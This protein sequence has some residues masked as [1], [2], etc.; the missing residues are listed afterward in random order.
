M[1]S[2]LPTPV[3]DDLVAQLRRQVSGPV[4]A[5][6]DPGYAEECRTYNL[7]TPLLPEVAVGA[8]SA[9]DVQAAVRLAA[10]HGLAVAI[11]GGGHIVATSGEGSLVINM[12]RMNAVTVDAEARRVRLQGSVLWQDVLDATA[13]YGLAPM[14]GSS[15]TVSAVG[16][17]LGGG[18]SPTLG[19]LLGWAA[20]YVTAF[21]LVTA[22]GVLRHVTPDSDPDLFFAVRGTKGNFG[23]VTALEL[24][25]FPF[26]RI[27]AGG[28]WFPGERMA[29]VLTSWREWVAG[30]PDEL[31]SSIAVQR[32]PPLPELPEPL[33]GAFVVHVRIAYLGDPEEGERLIRPLRS[34]APVI[35]D[36]VA[37]LPYAE[38]ATLHLD[39]PEPLPY[40]DR[41]TGLRDLTKETVDA[42][43][44]VAGPDSGCVLASI[45]IRR[46]GGALAREPRTPDA[47]PTRGLEFQMFAFGV[48]PV[49]T[50]PQLR[51][52]L[53]GLIEAV[54]PWHD[55]RRLVSF[56]SPDEAQQQ[57]DIE[58]LYGPERY[59]RLARIKQTYD[60]AN[61]FRINHNIAPARPA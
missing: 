50:M 51:A 55:P 42:L 58:E 15:P 30:T 22:D 26:T 9:E 4:F 10:E 37:D 43:V 31:T 20:E 7:M 16:Y 41:S 38:A 40:V 11:R 13:P 59:R 46:L 27:F 8:E 52:S 5:P 18:H 2:P 60:P 48:G 25:V 34:A 54:R 28:L 1:P 56:L 47:V 49:E 32:L 21:D 29:D 33:R 12:R 45:E 44:E 35:F 57:S 14:N 19:R 24:E 39:P 61:V 17:L 3:R 23:V 6:E 53:A 36:T